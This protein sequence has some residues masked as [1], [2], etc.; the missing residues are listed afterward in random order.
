MT[1]MFNILPGG[2]G[3]ER[4]GHSAGDSDL[5]VKVESNI[6]EDVYGRGELPRVWLQSK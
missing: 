6:S 3:N 5:N 4:L 2:L 1:P